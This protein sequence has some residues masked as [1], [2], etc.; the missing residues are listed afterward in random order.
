MKSLTNGWPLPVT[1]GFAMGYCEHVWTAFQEPTFKNVI[2]DMQI[3]P[4]IEEIKTECFT[5]L[6][7]Y[8]PNHLEK[9]WSES[10]WDD[11]P[12]SDMEKWNWCSKTTNQLKSSWFKP[13]ICRVLCIEP[14][15]QGTSVPQ[16]SDGNWFTEELMR[17]EIR[18]NVDGQA[19]VPCFLPRLV[20][21]P[22]YGKSLKL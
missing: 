11:S 7:V 21:I 4:Y 3:S 17:I 5:R 20:Y 8:L 14:A 1:M 10:Q 2:G 9:S 13:P 16:W 12:F 6:V 22:V 18:E 15:L 19:L